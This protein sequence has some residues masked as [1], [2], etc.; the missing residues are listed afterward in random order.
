MKADIADWIF[1]VVLKTGFP[2]IMLFAKPRVYR[3]SRHPGHRNRRRTSTIV[4]FVSDGS[5]IDTDE[6]CA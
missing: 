6:T 5:V 3:A 1:L 4:I 2:L